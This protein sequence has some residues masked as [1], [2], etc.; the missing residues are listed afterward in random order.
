MNLY[1]D[2]HC[3][4]VYF[5]GTLVMKS[6]VVEIDVIIQSELYWALI[7]LKKVTHLIYDFDCL[8]VYILIR[9]QCF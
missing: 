9:M 3:F 8:T 2:G 6:F 1:I 4:Y 7:L 5:R